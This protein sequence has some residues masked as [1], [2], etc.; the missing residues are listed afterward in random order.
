MFNQISS[1]S[2]N[3]STFA[4]LQS[5]GGSYAI[6]KPFIELQKI[7]HKKEK[8][9]KVNK[10]GI[11]LVTGTS[12][13][14]VGIF[15]ATQLLSGKFKF[16]ANR[17]A[18]FLEDT[19]A[20][21]SE[22]K[23]LNAAQDIYFHSL[24]GAKKIL[25]SSKVI[26]NFA[27]LKDILF[28]KAFNSTKTLRKINDAVTNWFE[29]VSVNTTKISYKSTSRK[30]D[31]MY[32][33]FAE[34]NGNISDK[35]QVRFLETKIKELKTHHDNGFGEKAREQRLTKVNNDLKTLFKD[36]WGNSYHNPKEFARRAMKGEFLAEELATNSK[37]NLN[38]TINDAKEKISI[39]VYDNY[40]EMKR[41]VKDID[42]TIGL[43][44]N[45]SRT[46]MRDL[47]THLDKYKKVLEEGESKANLPQKDVVINDLG[48]L[49]KY[50]LESDKYDKD[51]ANEVS[52][53]I[54]NLRE[55]L[56]SNK[57]GLVQN[58]MD[59]YKKNLS[60]EDYAKLKISVKKALKSLDTS[61]DLEGDKLFDKI[62]DLKLGSAP[63]DILM[64]L[65]SLVGVGWYL[66]KADNT[67]ERISA[68]LKFGI[69]VIGGAAIS[70]L[71]T[72]GLISS[73]PSLI[74]GFATGGLINKM[75]EWID[76]ARK[77]YNENQL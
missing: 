33:A 25:K 6:T 14:G 10:L 17:F 34:A 18:K 29:K 44:N 13:V 11:A 20:K 21:L 5:N 36:V 64:F 30:F 76:D 72:V 75:G 60:K 54:N 62:R 35:A 43:T 53:S 51:T 2:V 46:L 68:A 42:D 26:F 74:I 24:E 56:M 67:D 66:G 48:K 38:K 22:N 55:T 16:K 1:S 40:N 39:S 58:I 28:R 49:D 27:T 9:K 69:P 41:L 45:T 37:T 71:C 77:K 63:H 70:T 59:I 52:Q 31:K 57:Q 3:K 19:T 65:A 4:P 32:D 12:V 23:Q 8:E 73:G 15:F 47:R 50:I 61:V 7:E